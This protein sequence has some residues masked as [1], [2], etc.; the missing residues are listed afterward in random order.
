MSA[1]SDEKGGAGG[2]PPFTTAAEKH[3]HRSDTSQ[4]VQPWR[5]IVCTTEALWRR[6]ESQQEAEAVA[7]QLLHHGIHARAEV[8]Q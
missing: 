1:M 4:H 3:P 5:V 6:H 2:R 8:D 7:K